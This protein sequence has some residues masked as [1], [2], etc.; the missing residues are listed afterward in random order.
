MGNS[1]AWRVRGLTHFTLDEFSSPDSPG[2]GRFMDEEFLHLLDEA[3]E[4][5][6]IPFR[7]NSGFRTPERNKLVG[8]VAKSSHLTGFAADI[9]CVTSANRFRIVASLIHAGFDRLGISA[10]FI[11]V[12]NDPGK[13]EDVIWTYDKT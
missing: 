2:S 10:T 1:R 9:H 3:R 7:I 5:A 13:I 11:H 4:T 12:D 6:G 8:G